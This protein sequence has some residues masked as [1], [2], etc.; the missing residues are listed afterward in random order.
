MQR[1]ARGRIER[2]GVGVQGKVNPAARP[3]CRPRK[4]R[5]NRHR[6]IESGRHGKC[7][8]KMTGAA[9]VD[10]VADHEAESGWVILPKYSRSRD[11][12]IP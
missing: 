4:G 10:V 5:Q 12:G 7:P 8:M 1:S 11:A 9:M 6:R 3:G 2:F